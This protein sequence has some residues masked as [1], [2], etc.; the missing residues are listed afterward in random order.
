M[1][2]LIN[3]SNHPVQVK[4]IPIRVW[5]LRDEIEAAI[6]LRLQDYPDKSANEV[7]ISDIKDFYIGALNQGEENSDEEAEKSQEEDSNL[8]S[9][10]NPMDDDAL[11]MMAALG[12]G[13][14]NSDESDAPI[15][16]DDAATEEVSALEEDDEAAAMA[17][18]MLADQGMAAEDKK[19]E[20]PAEDDEAAALAMAMLADQGESSSDTLPISEE[21]K[22]K[23]FTRP[24]PPKELQGQGFTL[25]SDIQ[26]DK[27]LFFTNKNY[28][29]GQNVII[30]LNVPKPFSLIVEVLMSSHIGRKSKIISPNRFDYRVAGRILYKFEGER[31]R[32]REFL[33]AIEP[34]IPEPPKKLKRPEAEDDDDD[35]DDLG[36]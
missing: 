25:L 36:F 3:K 21:Q 7:D 4:K 2:N 27:L 16:E 19:E 34:E 10:G 24:T 15:N 14:E 26:M 23:F 9:S 20:L 8:D 32:L 17:A 35:F 11:A 30:K 31:S 22:P 33:K 13:E 12:G 1:S 18:A 6:S 28:I 5:K 29:Q